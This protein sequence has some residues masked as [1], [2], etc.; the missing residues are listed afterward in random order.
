MFVVCSL[1]KNTGF[2]VAQLA[3]CRLPQPSRW[4][5]KEGQGQLPMFFPAPALQ[6]S[7]HV[8]S[9]DPDPVFADSVLAIH[10]L[11]PRH[12]T[13]KPPTGVQHCDD[14]R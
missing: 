7:S 6:W 4:S 14:T 5:W 12:L 13:P 3:I 10:A 9:A 1:G 8:W 11:H 2:P